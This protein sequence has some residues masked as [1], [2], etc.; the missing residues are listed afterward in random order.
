MM[1]PRIE[2]SYSAWQLW[3]SSKKEKDLTKNRFYLYYIK[4]RHYEN[5][6]T[7]FGKK[8]AD[9]LKKKKTKDKEVEFC[10]SFLPVPKYR[11]KELHVVIDGVPI[12]CQLD[13]D[14]LDIID[15][16]K[17]GHLDPKGK[18]PWSQ[19]KADNWD[20]LT[21]YMMVKWRLTGK[22]PKGRLSWIPT[23]KVF[24]GKFNKKGEEIYKIALSG[25]FPKTWITERSIKD[26]MLLFAE[27]KKTY[28]EIQEFFKNI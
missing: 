7:I 3:K 10:R 1:M 12:L 22:N 16:F 28:E 4:D 27:L 5:P 11:E 15:E 19:K 13:G 20:Q 18:A 14:S 26:Y 24:T 21:I 9:G 8:I 23:K 17:T 25:E 6:E 2:L